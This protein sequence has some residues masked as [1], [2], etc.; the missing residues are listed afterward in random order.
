MKTSDK[1]IVTFDKADNGDD[2]AL[3]VGR[4]AF[5]TVYI[6]TDKEWEEDDAYEDTR[7]SPNV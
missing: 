3:L 5:D 4:E 2:A 6:L 1:L 7:N